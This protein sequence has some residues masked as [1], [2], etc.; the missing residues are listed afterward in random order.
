MHRALLSELRRRGGYP[1][2]TI[3]ANTTPGG[4]IDQ[5]QRL[6]LERLIETADRRLRNDVTDEVRRGV[7]GSLWILLAEAESSLGTDAVAICASPT[8]TAVVRLGQKVVERVTIDDRFDTRDLVADLNRTA[9]FRVVTVSEHQVRVL[10]GDRL[11][12]AEQ[13]DGRWPLEREAGQSIAS[14]TRAV[15]H[16]LRAEQRRHVVP[17]VVAGV[18]RSVRRALGSAELDSV[19]TIP[20]NH[21]RTSWAQLH[22]AAWPLVAPYIPDA[23]DGALLK[24]PADPQDD[25]P[26]ARDLVTS[27]V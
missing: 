5:T 13:I 22:A 4:W 20:G 1:C 2:V 18:E 8:Y 21:D 11:R 7:V 10:Y 24:P 9:T 23:D 25:S 14:W 26:L 19:A 6:H 15:V 12:L 16:A 17:T 3:L 27:A